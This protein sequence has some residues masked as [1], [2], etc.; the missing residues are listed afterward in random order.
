MAIT[1]AAAVGLGISAISTGVSFAQQSKQKKEQRKAENE[2]AKFLADARKKLDINFYEQLGIQKEPY[3]LAREAVTSTAAQAIEAGRE[4][5]RGAAATAGR[6]FLGA[7]Q[8]QRKIAT[9]MGQE[10]QALDKAVAE[11]EDQLRNMQ[12]NLD[13]SEAAGAQRAAAVAEARAAQ[14]GA[15][16]MKGVAS[17]GTQ[18]TGALSDYGKSEG[19]Q[20]FNKMEDLAMNKNNLSQADFQKSVAS[21]GT[22]GGV[23]FSKVGSMNPTAFESFM[24]GVNPNVLQQVSQQLPNSLQSFRP[25]DYAIPTFQPNF[26]SP[27]AMPSIGGR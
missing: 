19:T 10:M 3:E 5:E 22:V 26:Y 16:A 7:G 21:L 23:D 9:A 13:I 20:A 17:L 12:A 24:V 27:W 25:A 2:A 14:A 4:S 6:V 18:I 11:E 8:E 1:T 15:Q